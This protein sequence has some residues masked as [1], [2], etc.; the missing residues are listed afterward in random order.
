MPGFWVQRAVDP[1]VLAQTRQL[2]WKRLGEAKA[3]Y[4]HSAGYQ[5]HHVIPMYLGGLMQGTTYRLPTAYHKAITQA[6]R[7]EWRYGRSRPNAEELM[8]LITRVYSKYPIPQLIGI[9]P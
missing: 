3:L 5:N 1:K 4:P 7:Q 8:G 2:Y 9:E 6:F